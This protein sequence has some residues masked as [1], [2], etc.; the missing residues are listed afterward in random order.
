VGGAKLPFALVGTGDQASE[1]NKERPEGKELA[2]Y[3]SLGEAIA[4]IGKEEAAPAA[5]SEAA[6]ATEEAGGEEAAPAAEE[7]GGES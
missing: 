7:E 2:I 6:P 1:L 3:P 5:A 4:N